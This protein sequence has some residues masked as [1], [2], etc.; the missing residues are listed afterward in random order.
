M[1]TFSSLFHHKLLIYKIHIELK[2]LFFS[3]KGSFDNLTV[4]HLNLNKESE[5]WFVDLHNNSRFSFYNLTV[6][7]ISLEGMYDIKGNV[8]DLFDVYGKG[9]FW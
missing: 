6:Y 9:Y 5:N 1:I 8:G 2:I 3:L 7:N 4:S